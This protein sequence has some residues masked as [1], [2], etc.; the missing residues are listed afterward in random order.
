MSF[1]HSNF[2]LIALD[3]LGHQVVQ[4]LPQKLL[5]YGTNVRP[6]KC[7]NNKILKEMGSNN[8]WRCFL[9]IDMEEIMEIIK[10]TV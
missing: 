10:H 7:Q 3:F 5:I 2:I 1:A 6:Q 4:V 8:I 9:Q